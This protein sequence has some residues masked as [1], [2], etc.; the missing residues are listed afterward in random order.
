MKKG[1]LWSCHHGPWLAAMGLVAVLTTLASQNALGSLT[2]GKSDAIAKRGVLR[3]WDLVYL[4]YPVPLGRLSDSAS[5][6]RELQWLRPRP[7]GL[8]HHTIWSKAPAERKGK[9][10]YQ[11]SLHPT[12]V[13]SGGHLGRRTVSKALERQGKPLPPNWDKQLYLVEVLMPHGA[14]LTPLDTQLSRNREFRVLRPRPHEAD[15]ETALELIR[16]ALGENQRGKPVGLTSDV[17][18]AEHVGWIHAF[19][20]SAPSSNG[21]TALPHGVAS[22]GAYGQD[23]RWTTWCAGLTD[24]IQRAYGVPLAPPI[25]VRDLHIDLLLRSDRALR[26]AINGFNQQISNN[27]AGA[28]GEGTHRWQIPRKSLAYLG[29]ALRAFVAARIDNVGAGHEDDPTVF[30]EHAFYR[31]TDGEAPYEEV[32]RDLILEPL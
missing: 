12:T 21:L 15:P 29:A 14:T 30:S 28:N 5:T 6:P 2:E 9:L 18:W 10:E 13:V 23:S 19:A 4:R 26:H 25:Q 27:G 8:I 7:L 31:S 1:S 17:N 22:K 3:P 20:D 16:F 32:P 11:L 24:A